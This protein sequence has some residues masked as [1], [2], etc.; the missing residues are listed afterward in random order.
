[1]SVSITTT[2]T[3]KRRNRR[4]GRNRQR[5]IDHLFAVQTDTVFQGR[6]CPRRA[7]FPRP[8]GRPAFKGDSDLEKSVSLT[9]LAAGGLAFNLQRPDDHFTSPFIRPETKDALSLSNDAKMRS[10]KCPI[11]LASTFQ[12][13]P[14]C[15]MP[16]VMSSDAALRRAFN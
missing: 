3:S 1:L 7:P 4:A 10:Q 6:P 13:A 16:I 8:L 14:R 5:E 9:F 15:A 2:L 11:T 12:A